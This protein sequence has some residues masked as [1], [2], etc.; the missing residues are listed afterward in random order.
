MFIDFVSV[1]NFIGVFKDDY[2]NGD[3][4]PN[5]VGRVVEENH[6]E[7]FGILE[8]RTKVVIYFP[9]PRKMEMYQDSFEYPGLDLTYQVL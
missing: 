9:Y 5:I 1:F 7:T 8:E 6:S 4:G 3:F 2:L